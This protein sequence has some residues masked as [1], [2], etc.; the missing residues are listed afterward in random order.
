LPT[1]SWP[2]RWQIRGFLIFFLRKY[3]PR[4][5]A[6]TV[7]KDVFHVS[8]KNPKIEHQSLITVPLT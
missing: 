1:A 7:G 8:Q 6:R 3:V 4:T 5:R 2:G